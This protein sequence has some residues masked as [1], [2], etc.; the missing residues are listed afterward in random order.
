ME[1]IRNS[2]NLALG[3]SLSKTRPQLNVYK[4]PNDI[5]KKVEQ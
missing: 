2:K 5:K 1:E 3:D 4:K